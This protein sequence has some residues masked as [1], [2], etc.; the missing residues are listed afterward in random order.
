[1]QSHSSHHE[2]IWKKVEYF[3]YC[4]MII[5]MF[6]RDNGNDADDDDDEMSVA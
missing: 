3:V 2:F 4:S 6:N 5:G 1:M